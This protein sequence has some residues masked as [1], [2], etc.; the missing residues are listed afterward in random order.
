MA[1]NLIGTVKAG[2]PTSVR[3]ISFS[4]VLNSLDAL[5]EIRDLWG[6]LLR[7]DA[8]PFQTFAWN[9]A[10]YRKFEASYDE[11]VILVS[12][13][14]RAIFPMYRKG[15]VL[16]FAGDE[17]CDYQDAIALTSG[18][19]SEGFEE[20]VSLAG[21]MGARLQFGRLATRGLVYGAIQGMSPNR[22]WFDPLEK[23]LSPCPVFE[24]KKTTELTLAHLPRKFRAELRRQ[25]RRVESDFSEAVMESETA[26]AIR[27]QTLDRMIEFHRE[28]FHFSGRNPLS[29]RCL[30]DLISEV[31]NDPEVGLKVSRLGDEEITLASDLSF[32]R[33]GRFYGFMMAYNPTARRYSP[34]S[35][36][37]SFHLD[38]LIKEGVRVFDFLGGGETY[39]YRFS[40]DQ[41]FVRSVSL[42]PKTSSGMIFYIRLKGDRMIRSLTKSVLVKLGLRR[43]L[44]YDAESGAPD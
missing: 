10:W 8:S 14:E 2:S 27:Q 28:N 29:D 3:A 19:V 17:I 24:I 21:K 41:Y 34:G 15:G 6:A 5:K 12:S 26:P 31:R 39:K 30:V 25:G 9:E 38:R 11:I 37:L 22:E 23:T 42:F 35:C 20:L 32:T 43:E 4:G 33:G 36:L 1:S 13:S 16:R 40:T 44:S 18:D 7:P